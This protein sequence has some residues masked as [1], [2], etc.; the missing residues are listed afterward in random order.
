MRLRFHQTWWFNRIADADE[1]RSYKLS[2]M[3]SRST[4]QVLASTKQSTINKSEAG[5]DSVEDGSIT[6]G[7]SDTFAPSDK[8]DLV[9]HQIAASVFVVIVN[10]DVQVTNLTTVKLRGFMQENTQTG[11]IGRPRSGNSATEP[12]I[13]IGNTFHLRYICPW[14]L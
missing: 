11:T 9:D 13:R 14:W 10:S 12:W 2:S 4:I 8:S 7:T 5:L 3:V 1:Q 6:I